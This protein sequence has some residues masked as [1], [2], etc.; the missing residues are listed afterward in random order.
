MVDL[1]AYAGVAPS[2][3]P[4]IGQRAM[5]LGYDA[6]LAIAFIATAAD[7]PYRW[8]ASPAAWM[9]IYAMAVLR[10]LSVWPDFFRLLARNWTYLVY[11]AVCLASVMWSLSRGTSLVGSVQITMTVLVACYL[12]WRFRPRQLVLLVYWVLL[13]GT[14]A[15][16]LNLTLG[17]FGGT[18]FSAVGGLQGIYAN[19]NTLGHTSLFLML[20]ALTLLLMPRVEV[21]RATRWLAPLAIGMA[22]VA[23]VMS[24]SM[25]AIV[26]MPL[27]LGLV[28]L[29]N[30]RRLPGWLRH[31]AVALVI[32]AIAVTP[33]LLMLAGIDA[34]ALLFAATGKDATLTG[35]TELWAIAGA[36]IARV[37][38]TG[39]G[40]GAFWQVP[41]F[42]AQRFE[43]LRAG[44]TSPS[45]HNVVMDVG[46]GTGLLGIAAVLTLIL[47][48]LRRTLRFWRA[49]GG[50][51]AA[52][53]LATVLL[54]V[55]LSLV[56]PYLYR[57][58]E[59]MMA[60]L[61]ML[62]VSLWQRRHPSLQRRKE[63]R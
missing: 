27:Y 43:V 38:I 37:P 18:H 52:G 23:T 40:F 50:A 26:V 57:Q 21:P 6:A 1:T 61:I 31:G 59:F 7:L 16:I 17:L 24:K 36:E 42:E 25:T 8:G 49:D 12:G 19:K 48:A 45:F 62:G 33:A 29:L 56:E 30:R 60:W 55:N 22:A 4:R 58:H 15:S 47:T 13:A 3:R 32:L 2:P 35:R 14:G 11:P 46:V 10:F 28:M 20:L 51:L 41:Q 5:W 39:Y 54:P 63:T 44:A 9:A 34:M 53:C